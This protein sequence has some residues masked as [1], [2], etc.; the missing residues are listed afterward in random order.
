MARLT[1]IDY[2]MQVI[3]PMAAALQGYQAG[4]GQ[5]QQLDE[6]RRQREADEMA[7]QRFEAEM[8]QTQAAT[9]R[10]QEVQSALGDIWGRMADGE[11]VTV[12]DLQRVQS[13][14]PEVADQLQSLTENLTAQEKSDKFFDTVELVSLA[15][16]PELYRAELNQR[17]EASESNPE[18]QRALQ[19]Q[20]Q[21]YDAAEQAQEGGGAAYARIIGGMSALQLADNEQQ[22]E[23]LSQRLFPEPEEYESAQD[24]L[25]VRRYTEG[26]NIGQP[27]PGFEETRPTTPPVQLKIGGGLYDPNTGQ[28]ILPSG[29]APTTT[30]SGAA[31]TAPTTAAGAEQPAQDVTPASLM[32]A[33]KTPTGY[34]SI[35]TPEGNMLQTIRNSPQETASISFA[36]NTIDTINLINDFLEDP[37]APTLYGT[38]TRQLVLSG[39]RR[40]TQAKLNQLLGGSFLTAVRELK[41]AGAGGSLTENEGRTAQA[42]QTRFGDTLQ[43][44]GD[45][46]QAL[47]DYR[48][49]L[50]RGLN[51]SMIG[52][53]PEAWEENQLDPSFKPENMGGSRIFNS[54]QAPASED[55]GAVDREELE[56]VVQYYLGSR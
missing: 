30:P 19:A 28:I 41:D 48:E 52:V 27:V 26:P 47:I 43:E 11:N 5:M 15:Q 44:W 56:A 32:E 1:P 36:A 12:Q 6:V 39:P 17:I 49:K 21:A 42:A 9:A 16:T 51:R 37:N 22:R 2:Q 40:G 33:G 13:R 18:Q 55:L 54:D 29:A 35:P 10:A 14:F 3:N 20:L 8:A 24:A 53:R 31:P 7:K 25:G 23:V 46:K 50:Q 38:F 4:F 34:E 45:A